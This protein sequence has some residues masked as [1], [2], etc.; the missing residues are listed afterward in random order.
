MTLCIRQAGC[1][2]TGG[3]AGPCVGAAVPCPSCDEDVCHV[4]EDC[5]WLTGYCDYYRC[6]R[7]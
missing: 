1:T 5:Y 6:E 4:Q 2:W 7:D 3:G